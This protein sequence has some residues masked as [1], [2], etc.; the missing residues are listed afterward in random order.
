MGIRDWFRQRLSESRDALDT[1]PPPARTG[2]PGAQARGGGPADESGSVAGLDF[3]SAIEAHQR[4]KSRLADWLEGRS[5]EPLDWRAICRDDQC[6]LGKWL[7]GPGATSL[8]GHALFH[9]LRDTHAD[10]HQAAGEIVRLAEA[11][12]RSQAA[13]TLQ[14]GRYVRL[15][16]RVQGQLA[17]LYLQAT[18][19]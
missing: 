13:E 1:Q 8:G 4:W 15:S 14:R 9:T 16:L 3:R 2:R 17:Q 7:Y 12:D 6:P 18:E 19:A 5:D 10:F 11:G